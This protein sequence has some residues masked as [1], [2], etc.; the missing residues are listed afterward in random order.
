MRGQHPPLP[1]GIPLDAGGK[2]KSPREPHKFASS[3]RFG[4]PLPDFKGAWRNGNAAACKAA[5][6]GLD[7]RRALQT[8]G[9]F[10]SRIPLS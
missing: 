6:S 2:A 4:V 9:W 1:P 3:V 5:R 8:P 7:T 10:R